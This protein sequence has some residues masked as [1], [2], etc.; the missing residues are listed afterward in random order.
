MFITCAT[1]IRIH[2][3]WKVTVINHDKTILGILINNINARR[4]EPIL[5]IKLFAAFNFKLICGRISTLIGWLNGL[6][7]CT[8]VCAVEKSKKWSNFSSNKRSEAIK[9]KSR[10]VIFFGLNHIR[11][12]IYLKCNIFSLI[13]SNST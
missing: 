11:I 10:S 12:F 2:L 4:Y 8:Y 7:F 6:F 9:I 13:W 5:G 3:D 1:K